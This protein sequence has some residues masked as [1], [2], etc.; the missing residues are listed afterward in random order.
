MFVHC[1]PI[2]T[3]SLCRHSSEQVTCVWQTDGPS[4]PFFCVFFAMVR[5]SQGILPASIL[6]PDL[7]GKKDTKQNKKEALI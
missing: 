3:L 7:E 1:F 6:I 4:E 2:K 5:P